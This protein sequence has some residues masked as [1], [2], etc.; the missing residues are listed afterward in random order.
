MVHNC[1][2]RQ[3]GSCVCLEGGGGGFGAQ[4]APP[5]GGGPGNG[6]IPLIGG[7]N[8]FN[9]GILGNP[10]GI[11][12]PSSP[13]VDPTY[14][15]YDAYSIAPSPTTGFVRPTYQTNGTA[16]DIRFRRVLNLSATINGTPQTDTGYVGAEPPY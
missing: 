12:S 1:F 16:V 3:S 4:V 2:G 6:S 15:A 11:G 9:A 14:S 10:P 5:S 7:Q 8:D 13:D